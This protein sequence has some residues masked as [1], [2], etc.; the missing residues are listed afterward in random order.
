LDFANGQA[1]AVTLRA[2]DV[3]DIDAEN[4]DVG[5]VAGLNDLLRIDGMAA[6]R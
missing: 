3:L 1:S 2:A 6:T 4:L 5:G